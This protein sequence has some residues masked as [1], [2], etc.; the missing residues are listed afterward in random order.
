MTAPR[1]VSW[2]VLE[3]IAFDHHGSII[4]DKDGGS[5]WYAAPEVPTQ[6]KAAR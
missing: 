2:D 1:T 4:T 5:H 3:E 6:N